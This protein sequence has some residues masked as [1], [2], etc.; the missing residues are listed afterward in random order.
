MIGGVCA[1]IADHFNTDVT[2]I[3]V[4]FVVAAAATLGSVVALYLVLWIVIPK[5]PVDLFTNPH[6]DYR[7]DQRTAAPLKV[8]RDGNGRIIGGAIMVL[9][10]LIFLVN[11]FFYLPQWLSFRYLWPLIIIIPGIVLLINGSSSPGPNYVSQ[12][13]PQKDAGTDQSTTTN[14]SDQSQL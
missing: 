8:K 9:I 1:G 2:W 4:G 6:V 5:R 10:G 7:A 14:P 3:R 12:D 11:E 13:Q